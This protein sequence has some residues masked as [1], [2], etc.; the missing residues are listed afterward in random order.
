MGNGTDNTSW[1][2]HDGLWPSSR[3]ALA[4]VF[5]TGEFCL[6][7]GRLVAVLS[8]SVDLPGRWP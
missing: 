3:T 1:A 6:P 5:D 2:R 4:A 7:V 8:N